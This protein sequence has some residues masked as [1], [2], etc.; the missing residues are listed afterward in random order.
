MEVVEA[1]VAVSALEAGGGGGGM[2]LEKT[3]RQ[4]EPE[5]MIR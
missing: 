3:R 1:V 2:D 5:K 4:Q